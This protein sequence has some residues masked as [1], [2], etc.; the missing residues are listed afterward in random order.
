VGVKRLFNTA[1]DIYYYR[2]GRIKSS[3]IEDLIIFLYTSRF[4][5]EEEEARLLK[6]FF[7]HNKIEAAKEEKDKKLNEIEI[8]PI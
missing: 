4:N 1:R 8:E 6:K 2:R 5:I 7:S 3:T